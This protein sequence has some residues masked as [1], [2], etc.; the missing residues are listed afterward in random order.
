MAPEHVING[1]T[2]HLKA[3]CAVGVAQRVT[4]NMPRGI[5]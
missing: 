5:N 2:L 4:H 3:V 1:Q